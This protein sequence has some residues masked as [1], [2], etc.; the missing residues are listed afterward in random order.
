MPY[1]SDPGFY[2]PTTPLE[3]AWEADNQKWLKKRHEKYMETVD[4]KDLER[5]WTDE[6]AKTRKYFDDNGWHFE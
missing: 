3:K 2:T 6:R 4:M 1:R 5:W